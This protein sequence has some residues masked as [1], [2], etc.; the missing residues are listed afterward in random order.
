[1]LRLIPRASARAAPAHPSA[2]TMGHFRKRAVLV[3]VTALLVFGS[4]P[5]SPA[6]PEARA[7]A[8]CGIVVNGG[9]G[10]ATS[11]WGQGFI[12]CVGDV[13]STS[14][15]LSA[16][17]CSLDLGICWIW[18][19]GPTFASCSKGAVLAYWCPSGGAAWANNLQRG[20]LYRIQN[21]V[22]LHSWTG[23]WSSGDA[24]TG[25]FRL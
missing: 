25:S 8:T 11:A 13:A 7:D 17:P 15:S 5:S 22:T 19:N 24:F 2:Q 20:T 18:G 16:D 23:G 12:S 6:V 1:M 10:G 3:A 9:R 14:Q 4:M 21:H